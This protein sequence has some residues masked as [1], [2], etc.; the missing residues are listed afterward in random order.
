MKFRINKPLFTF[1]FLLFCILCEYY[2][3][4][5]SNNLN[6]VVPHKDPAIE[7][8]F[9]NNY[10]AISQKPTIFIGAGVP[11]FSP[12]KIGDIFVSTTT[13]KIYISTATSTPQGWDVVN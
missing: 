3:F 4:S 7:R 11:A 1:L 2:A 12:S 10:Q 8:E 6:P 13:S 5:A 9:Q